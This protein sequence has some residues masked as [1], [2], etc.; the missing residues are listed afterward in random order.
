MPDLRDTL[1]LDLDHELDATRKI[2]AAVPW[3][4]A[5]WTPHDKSMSLGKLATHIATLPQ[6][7]LAAV[8]TDGMDVGQVRPPEVEIDST[9]DLLGVWDEASGALR[10]ALSEAADEY[11]EAPWTM[12][13]NGHPMFENSRHAAVRQW[14]LSHIAHHRGQLTVYLRL[15]DV[16][17]P[18]VYGP[19]ADDRAKMAAAR[20]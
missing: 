1:F 17:F 6:F 12:S 11:L 5:D 15:L 14:A 4:R 8:T 19:S 7:G 13:V 3:D 18:G 16:P 20:I 2:L 9:D 10:S